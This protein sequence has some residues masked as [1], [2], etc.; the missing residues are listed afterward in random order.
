MVLVRHRRPEQRED[1]VVGRLHDI[2][3]V[4]PH[5]LDHQ[6]Q[7]RIDNAAGLFGIEVLHQLGRA[8]DIGEQRRH[9][10]ALTLERVAGRL[11]RREAYSGNCR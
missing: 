10:L 2:A 8:L 6:L 9:R 4:T 5:R 7:R 1:A 3:T 11:L